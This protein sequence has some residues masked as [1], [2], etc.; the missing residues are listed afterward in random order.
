MNPKEI[1][2][3]N[4]HGMIFNGLRKRKLLSMLKRK[5]Y[6]STHFPPN[7][8]TFQHNLC[9]YE[10]W[11]TCVMFLQLKHAFWH[12]CNTILSFSIPRIS[13]TQWHWVKPAP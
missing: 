9:L 7:K 6:M 3:K 4:N 8:T 1:R 2:Y 5:V 13:F 11:Y 12:V 10:I